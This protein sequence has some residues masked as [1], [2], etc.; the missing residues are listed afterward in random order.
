[1][2]S[3]INNAFAHYLNIALF[4]CG[5]SFRKTAVPVSLRAELYRARKT[6]ETFDSCAVI[7]KTAGG[8]EFQALFSH[9]TDTNFNPEV[10]IVCEKGTA[11]W[12]HIDDWYVKDADG[13]V[14]DSGTMIPPLPGMFDIVTARL[15]D[16]S[17]FIYPLEDAMRQVQC[18]D[19]IAE[20][21]VSETEEKFITRAEKDGQ[22]SVKDLPEV[23]HECFDK[24]VLPSQCTCEWACTTQEAVIR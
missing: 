13:K 7:G 15:E 16:D 17:Q 20:M 3:P 4:L 1:M 10:R 19:A 9:A 5:D 11:L 2:D 24:G 6:I 23:F 8:A 12:T 18:I 22:L 21:Q 14:L